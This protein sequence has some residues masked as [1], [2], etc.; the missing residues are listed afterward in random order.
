[1]QTENQDLNVFQKFKRLFSSISQMSHIGEPCMYPDCSN[2]TSCKD[3]WRT[4][5][6]NFSS[7]WASFLT[8]DNGTFLSCKDLEKVRSFLEAHHDSERAAYFKVFPEQVSPHAFIQ[9]FIA[10]RLLSEVMRYNVAKLDEREKRSIEKDA[11][12]QSLNPTQMTFD[13]FREFILHGL[14]RENP[15]FSDRYVD[16]VARAVLSVVRRDSSRGAT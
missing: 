4:R 12:S 2:I 14:K 5:R 11:P 1:M 10:P 7:C 15:G 9:Y 8:A 3:I 6:E 16:D 13:E